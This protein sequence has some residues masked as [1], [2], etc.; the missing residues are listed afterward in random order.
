MGQRTSCG[1][2]LIGI[3][4]LACPAASAAAPPAAA[5]APNLLATAP[6]MLGTRAVPIRADRFSDSLKRAREDASTSPLLQRLIAP[7]RPMPPLQKMAFIQSAVTRSIHWISDATEWGQHDYWASA[8]QTLS[9]GAG[10]AKNRAIVKLHA[11]RALGFK[12]SD[13]FLTLARDRVGGPLTVLTV[14]SGGRYYVM[15]DTGGRPFAVEE[16]RLEFQPVMSFGMYGAWVHVPPTAMAS[17]RAAPSTVAASAA[18]SSTAGR[19]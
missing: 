1:A 10:D 4:V 3:A 16:R 17:S 13:L 14:R 8:S 18:N 6:D 19:P 2:L 5:R 11:L 9:H 7:A 15:D 12:N